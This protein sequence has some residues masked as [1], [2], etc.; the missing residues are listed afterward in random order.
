MSKKDILCI[1]TAIVDSIIRG[2]DPVPVSATGYRAESGALCVGGE[3]VNAAM[4]A[5]K[6]GADVGILCALGQ[7]AAGSLIRASLDA[8]GVD[9]SQIVPSEATPITTMFVAPDGSRKSI[10]NSAH[11]WNFHPERYTDRIH[12]RAVL[13]GSLFR[14]PFDDPAIIRAVLAAAKADGAIT[15]ADTKLP[16]FRVL[17]LLDL[18]DSLPLIDWITPNEDEARHYTG[19]NE[20]ERMANALLALGVRNVIVKLGAR[21][22]FYKGEHGTLRLDA[23]PIRAVDATGAGDTFAAGFLSELL[24]GTDPLDAVRFGNACGAITTTMV[25]ASA[26]LRSREQVLEWLEPKRKIL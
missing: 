3:S 16:N 4:A 8:C 5:A 17:T 26:A 18:S 19:E 13:L 25:G 6:L 21:G 24:R 14:A 23:L 2:L 9:T 7:D 10:T 15:V 1:G 22:C 20:P 12:A 11:R